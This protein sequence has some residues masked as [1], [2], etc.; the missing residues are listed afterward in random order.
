MLRS[1]CT[2]MLLLLLSSAL[3]QEVYNNKKMIYIGWDMPTPQ[4]LREKYQMMEEKTPFFDGITTTLAVEADGRMISDE[5]IFVDELIKKEWLK[6]SIEDIKA[7]D[8]KVFKHNYVRVNVGVGK[9]QW[10]DDKAWDI[11]VKNMK[12]MAW[13]AKEAGLEGICWDMESY[14]KPMF[15]YKASTGYTFEETQAFAR[16]RGQQVMKAVAKE[17]PDMVFWALHFLDYQS[18]ITHS[19]N[20]TAVLKNFKYGMS[21]AFFNGLFDEIPSEMKF[22][23]GN[24][25]AY[26]AR[27]REDL[28]DLYNSSRSNLSI[29]FEPENK[30]KYQ[31]QIRTGFGLYTDMYQRYIGD[32]FYLGPTETRTRL[33]RFRDRVQESLNLCDEYIWIYNEGNRWWDIPFSRVGQRPPKVHNPLME[34]QFPGIKEAFMYAK[35]PAKYIAKVSKEKNFSMFNLVRNGDFNDASPT[36]E[37]EIVDFVRA[38]CPAEFLMWK[39]KDSRAKVSVHPTGGLDNSPALKV[40]GDYCTVNQVLDVIPEENYAIMVDGMKTGGNFNVLIRYLDD[41]DNMVDW[42]RWKF[43]TFESDKN[44]E[45]SKAV[46]MVKVPAEVKRMIIVMFFYPDENSDDAFYI[47]NLTAVK[48]NHLFK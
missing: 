22:V 5:S 48:V 40:E 12:T 32:R 45:W 6:S 33:E 42:Y 35:N 1:F 2:L 13:F 4:M 47:D 46:G 31:T 20:I 18:P 28:L 25:N 37:K 7:C 23:D 19:T 17:Y 3:T 26:Y 14:G 24:E 43:L 41:H 8:F 21:S 27:N 9:L 16:K 15:E 29:L 39:G 34:E 11:A 44:K 10:H 36:N 38:D 30:G